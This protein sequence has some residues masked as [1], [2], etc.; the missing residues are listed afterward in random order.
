MTTTKDVNIKKQSRQLTRMAFVSFVVFA[1]CWLPY[2]F[3]VA[4]DY[5]DV[6]PL[7]LHLYALLIAHLNSSLNN[8]VYGICNE[9]F[10][11]AYFRLLGLDRCIPSVV[12]K[13][14]EQV[15]ST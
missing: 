12:S 7:E 10:R 1:V 15:V 14:W 8:I 2:A 6:Y 9:S 11:H 13:D 3:I 5:N 4:L